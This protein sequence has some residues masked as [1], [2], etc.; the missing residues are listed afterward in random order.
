MVRRNLYL[1]SRNLRRQCSY[2]PPISKPTSKMERWDRRRAANSSHG[3]QRIVKSCL[4]C[5]I[6]SRQTTRIHG[7]DIFASKS[8]FKKYFRSRKEA[9]TGIH[10]YSPF[11]LKI[12]LLTFLSI[13]S[14][15]RHYLQLKSRF[16][17]AAVES[18]KPKLLAVRT[19]VAGPGT[20]KL[21]LK[22]L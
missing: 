21:R 3:V 20:G 15:S 6:V 7:S 12:R 1:Y 19:E 22:S 14:C 8:H 10:L 4:F 18:F 16:L 9:E 11:F 2:N 13:S 5:K 17:N